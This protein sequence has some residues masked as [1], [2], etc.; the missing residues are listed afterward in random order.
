MPRPD[1]RSF[2]LPIVLYPAA[3]PVAGILYLGLQVASH[4]M[5][6]VRPLVLTVTLGL[7]LTIALTLVLR[8]KHRAGLLAWAWLVGLFVAVPAASVAILR[9]RARHRNRG[10]PSRSKA[11]A[12]RAAHH[13]GDDRVLRRPPCGHVLRRLAVGSP[14]GTDRRG[15]L[16]SRQRPTFRADI[17]GR[18]GTLR[19]ASRW[20][21][22]CRRRRPRADL[23]RRRL[24]EC[25]PS[26]WIR[27][28]RRL[29][30]ELPDDSADVGGDVHRPVPRHGP[31]PFATRDA[32]SR[33]R[34]HY[35]LQPTAASSWPGWRRVATSESP[36]PRASA[37]SGRTALIV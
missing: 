9:L 14:S 11:M 25:S 35:A 36:S 8:D 18:R 24:P 32:C 3:T 10:A 30:L 37:R 28:G 26:A 7:L 21:S 19:R 6:L 12:D 23:R 33:T 20:L 15:G 4:P 1:L 13:L 16:R 17:D 27:R 29:P 5:W 22:G 2:R 31:E 34:S